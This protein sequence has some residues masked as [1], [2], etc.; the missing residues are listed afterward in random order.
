MIRPALLSL[1]LLAPL[2]AG[3]HFLEILPQADVLPEGGRVELDLVFTHPFAG[4]P[5]MALERPEEVGVV[6]QSGRETLTDRLVETPREGRS[7]WHL[8]YDLPAPGGA[9]FYV[10]PK[11]YWEAAEGK[12]IRHHAKV[13]VDAWASG[14]GLEAAVGLPVEIV[15]LMRPTGLWAGNLFRGVVLREGVPVPGAEI[16]VEFVN[17]AGIEA[18]NDAYVTQVIRADAAGVFAY[19]MPFAGWWGF[20][21]L[22]EGAALPGPDGAP[23]PVEEG[24]LIW[25]ETRAPGGL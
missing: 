12:F 9:I 20:A 3:A 5:V 13:A 24:G 14:E 22:L 18:P 17:T 8:S 10:T 6:T 23:A 4:G 21:A 7:A 1:A 15:P 11:P 19:A 16:E 25:I 2:P